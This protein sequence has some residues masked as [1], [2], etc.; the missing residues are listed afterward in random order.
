MT[1]NIEVLINH[2][3]RT[4]QEIYS[5]GLIPYKTKLKGDLGC[6]YVSLN[7]VRESVYLA[8]KREN[9]ILFV[10]TITLIDRDKPSYQFSNE[11]PSP[12]ISM[13]SRQWVHEQFGEPEKSHPPEMIMKHQFG[14][15][16]LYTL[17]DFRIPT[18]MQISYDLL[19]RVEY[20]TFLPTSEVRW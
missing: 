6:D 2:L 4:Y 7:M 8:F 20:I 9:K 12:L 13:M 11:L 14:R 19:D 16:D 3:G 5:K 1:I 10:V 18:N 17:L 15:K